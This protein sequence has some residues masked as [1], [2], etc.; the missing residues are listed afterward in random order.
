M[1]KNLNK[2][3]HE[4]ASKRD[5]Y[6][7]NLESEV[8]NNINPDIKEGE[9]RAEHKLGENEKTWSPTEFTPKP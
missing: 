8:I 1:E 9:K 4:A 5:G 3:S 2:V 7:Q 6:I